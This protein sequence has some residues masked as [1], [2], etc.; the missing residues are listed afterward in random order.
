M[1]E[2]LNYAG[3]FWWHLHLPPCAPWK[4]RP[5]G[6]GCSGCIIS[7][8]SWAHPFY[9]QEKLLNEISKHRR[10]S[11]FTYYKNPLACRTCKRTSHKAPAHTPIHSTDSRVM[12]YF[13]QYQWNNSQCFE[14]M[15][16]RG[17]GFQY[18]NGVVQQ[19]RTTYNEQCASNGQLTLIAAYY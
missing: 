18:Q 13:H 5:P 15:C 14:N 3:P 17:L 7:L 10:R 1:S 16:L 8:S 9:I 6:E 4:P 12:D 2:N 19:V 11:A